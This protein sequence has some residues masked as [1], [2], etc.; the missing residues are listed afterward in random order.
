[1]SVERTS[2]EVKFHPSLVGELAEKLYPDCKDAF[3][4]YW[5]NAYDVDSLKVE[6]KISPYEVVIEDWGTG[7][8]SFIDFWMIGSPH[9]KD[10]NESPI[11]KR[12]VI[13]K[14]GIGKLSFRKI[15]EKI[16]AI[17]R[18]Q[19]GKAYYSTIDFKEDK[20]YTTEYKDRRDI[21]AILSHVGTKFKISQLTDVAR[22]IDPNDVTEYC[23]ENMYGIMLSGIATKKPMEIIVN[24]KI[25]EAKMPRGREVRIP[26]SFG[27][28]NGVLLP[29]KKTTKID[30][31]RRG[32]KIKDINPAPT[33]PAEG[34]F[35]SNWLEPTTDRHDFVTDTPEYGTFYSAVR[36]YM[37]KNIPSSEEIVSR[38]KIKSIRYL[39]DL[40]G[41]IIKDVGLP[42]DMSMP[43]IK[44]KEP[45]EAKPQK[46]WVNPPETTAE[47]LIENVPRIV[48]STRKT[49]LKPTNKPIRSKYGIS[50]YPSNCGNDE[51]AI[52][53][54]TYAKAVI[55]NMDHEFMKRC[56]DM[57][58][59]EQRLSLVPLFARGY[60]LLM[61]K[62]E[63][64][65]KE[66]E[67]SVDNISAKLISRIK[68]FS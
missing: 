63:I 23:R 49:P 12:P 38:R 33:H 36:N 20:Y 41:D 56:D 47:K 65:M 34:F 21:E 5:S 16:D 3:R 22:N 60:T 68:E 67:K 18:T 64:S 17:T 11:L 40:M 2:G 24:D 1:M 53:V 25:V 58:M 31:L 7:V 46:N 39:A 29:S 52:L 10:L 15:G 57:R 8:E 9:K 30:A 43:D 4:E 44:F 6:T 54:D 28:I 50:W 35:N 51:P 13:G 45:E 27:E 66:F 37:I 19:N 62:Q 32:I 61:K 59:T 26:C 48:L 55:F 14:K 42:K